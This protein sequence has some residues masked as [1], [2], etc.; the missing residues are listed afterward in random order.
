M[1]SAKE[2]RALQDFSRLANKSHLHPLDWQRFFE[3]VIV[4]HEDQS[5]V[6]QSLLQSLLER[7]GFD[8]GEINRLV[9]FYDLSRD[10]LAYLPERGMRPQ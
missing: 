7:E 5:P 1:V 3:F 2:E 8:R 10:L 9:D 4:G 6:D